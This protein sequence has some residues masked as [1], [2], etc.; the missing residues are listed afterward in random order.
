MIFIYALLI[1]ILILCGWIMITLNEV[2]RTNQKLIHL[3]TVN[4]KLMDEKINNLR[5]ENGRDS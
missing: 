4:Q 1:G 5:D 3:V 2:D